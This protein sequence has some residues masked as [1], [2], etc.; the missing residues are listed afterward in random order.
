MSNWKLVEQNLPRFVLIRWIFG[1]IA[2][3]RVNPRATSYRNQGN[4]KKM[5]IVEGSHNSGKTT[6]ISSAFAAIVHNLFPFHKI[7]YD[8]VEGATI[9]KKCDDFAAILDI[10]SQEK[11]YN[12]RVGFWSIG[13]ESP[14][15]NFENVLVKNAD[16]DVIVCA[17]TIKQGGANSS[18]VSNA[19]VSIGRSNGYQIE[20]ISR[21]YAHRL[22]LK[23]GCL[24]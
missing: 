17:A 16:C 13:D 15:A 4:S 5:I 8:F 11:R 24:V 2:Y 6:A 23:L 10:N 20:R 19:L 18:T 1:N 21:R 7:S 12:V 14:D 9:G 3:P 22:V